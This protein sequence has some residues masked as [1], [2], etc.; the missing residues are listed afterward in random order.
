MRSDNTAHSSPEKPVAA[1]GSQIQY[2]GP[3]STIYSHHNLQPGTSTTTCT[4]TLSFS[5]SLHVFKIN[6]QPGTT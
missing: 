3:G 1:G 5:L 4:H 2:Q 6:L